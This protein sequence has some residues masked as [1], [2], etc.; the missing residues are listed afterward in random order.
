VAA[1]HFQSFAGLA[2]C[3]TLKRVA[4]GV[5]SLQPFFPAVCDDPDLD[6]MGQK[7]LS[8]LIEKLTGRVTALEKKREPSTGKGKWDKSFVVSLVALIA[9]VVALPIMLASWIEP[10]LQNDLKSDVKNEVTDQLKEPLNQIGQ[11]A[12]D[13]SEIKGKLEVLDPLI[14]DLTIKRISAAGNLSPKELHAQLPELK[15]LAKTAKTEKLTIAPKAI[16]KVG[17]KLAE[18]GDADAWN[19]ALDFVNY[20]SFLNASLSL[21]LTPSALGS[22]V[23]TTIY[24]SNSPPGTAK[25]RFS[26]IGAVP[27]EQAARL[28]IMGVPDLNAN[29]TIGND[30]IVVDGGNLILDKM[31]LKKAIL[32]NVHIVYEGGPLLMQDVYFINCTFDVRQQSN[33]QRLVMAVLDPSP[34]VSFKAS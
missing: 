30:W 2:P 25:P 12:R 4:T 16:E 29:L 11:I 5:C 6:E 34:A 17:A 26:V 10:H 21:P 33:G 27:R 23:F 32:R 15:R 13:V 22:G 14:R 31:E 8:T 18:V 1:V 7:E 19:T 28:L 3:S 9:A 20:K 24:R